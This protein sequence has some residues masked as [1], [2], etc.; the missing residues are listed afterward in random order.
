MLRTS[1]AVAAGLLRGIVRYI[2]CIYWTTIGNIWPREIPG[3][4]VTITF[5]PERRSGRWF[6]L[7]AQASIVRIL[8]LRIDGSSRTG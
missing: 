4:V 2:S 6:W 5:G 3:V 8:H 7:R 1:V